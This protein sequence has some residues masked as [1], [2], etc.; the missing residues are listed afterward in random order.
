MSNRDE[1]ARELRA[2]AVRANA[3][4]SV[5]RVAVIGAAPGCGATTAAI[6]VA[7]AAADAGANTVCVI[8][9]ARGERL[10]SGTRPA[11]WATAPNDVLAA[12]SRRDGAFVTRWLDGLAATPFQFAVLECDEPLLREIAGKSAAVVLTTTPDPQHLLA[13][14]SLLKRFSVRAPWRLLVNRVSK[15]QTA[16]DV[17]ARLAATCRQFMDRDLAFGGSLVERAFLPIAGPSA[18]PLWNEVDRLARA[19]RTSAAP[20][21]R[22]S[23]A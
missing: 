8:E 22:A 9:R 10:L 5:Q 14:Y 20:P 1:Q 15:Q 4:Q 11:S 3:S 23:A 17:H 13:S 19:C 6:A 16:V 18:G 2:M 21:R 7:D 12:M